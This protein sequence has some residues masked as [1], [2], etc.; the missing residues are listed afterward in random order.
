M[1]ASAVLRF[2]SAGPFWC[3]DAIVVTSD[4]VPDLHSR[5]AWISSGALSVLATIILSPVAS[6]TSAF[7]I[8]IS[9]IASLFYLS[10]IIQLTLVELSII[11][12][13]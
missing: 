5:I 13:K 6:S 9:A 1:C 10:G 11:R 12:I 8:F 2:R 4:L 7:Y 3:D